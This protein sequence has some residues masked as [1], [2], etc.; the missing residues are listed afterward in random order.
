MKVQYVCHWHAA[1]FMFY[2]HGVSGSFRY[3]DV[4]NLV[5]Q[6]WRSYLSICEPIGVTK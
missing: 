2:I 5:L 3:E 6:T 1:T 4:L